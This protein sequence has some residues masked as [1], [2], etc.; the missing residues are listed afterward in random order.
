MRILRMLK[1]RWK[2]IFTNSNLIRKN[3][4]FSNIS[5]NVCLCLRS[6]FI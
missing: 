2:R 5:W 1:K 4:W 6:A 3:S